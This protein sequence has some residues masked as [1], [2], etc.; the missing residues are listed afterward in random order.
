VNSPVPGQ[1]LARLQ[2]CEGRYP[3]WHGAPDACPLHS[4]LAR[5]NEEEADGKRGRGGAEGWFINTRGVPPLDPW[6][7]RGPLPGGLRGQPAGGLTGGGAWVQG[8]HRRSRCPAT[9][10]LLLLCEVHGVPP[11]SL[12]AKHRGVG[13]KGGRERPIP[14]C[15]P[16]I[17]RRFW[18]P[19]AL[20]CTPNVASNK[21]N[22]GTTVRFSN[23]RIK[24][25]WEGKKE[26]LN[27]LRTV[28]GY[29]LHHDPCMILFLTC[30]LITSIKMNLSSAADILKPFY[31]DLEVHG[32]TCDRVTDL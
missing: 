26:V 10:P 18:A 9:R 21:S 12:G 22:P 28:N 19:S 13:V 14:A 31:L 2:K 11:A 30:F 17:K 27:S 29:I 1:S 7:C 20:A 3:C 32:S 24:V 4:G 8:A 6:P 5:D 16:I 23:R 15:S 25:E